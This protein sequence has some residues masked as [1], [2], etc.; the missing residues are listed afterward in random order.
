MFF[1]KRIKNYRLTSEDEKFRLLKKFKADFTVNIKFNRNF[2]KITA[3][4][5]IKNIIFR[6]INPKRI[7]VSNNFRFGN[8]RKGDVKLLKKFRKKV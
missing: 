4:N 1:N 2:S 7:F 8:K 3:K 5:F 6:K